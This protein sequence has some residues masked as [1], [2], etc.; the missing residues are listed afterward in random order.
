VQHV[1]DQILAAGKKSY[2]FVVGKVNAAKLANFSEVGG[3]VVIGCWESSLIESKDFETANHAFRA[4]A[5]A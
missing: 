5:R 3:W 4:G 1:Q 2:T